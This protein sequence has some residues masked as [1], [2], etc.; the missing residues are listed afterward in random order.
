VAVWTANKPLRTPTIQEFQE[1]SWA[2]PSWPR[3]T[4]LT[5]PKRSRCPTPTST[6]PAAENGDGNIQPFFRPRGD[7]FYL[8][9]DY[10]IDIRRCLSWGLLR[11]D[12]KWFETLREKKK[13]IEETA[14]RTIDFRLRHAGQVNSVRSRRC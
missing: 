5:A 13:F 9:Q 1:E 2:T 12:L 8:Q 14:R 6:Q 11:G 7:K 3:S 10:F 4:N